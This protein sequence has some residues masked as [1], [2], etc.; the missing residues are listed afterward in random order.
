MMAGK[1]AWP[2]K[3]LDYCL[4]ALS[5]SLTVFLAVA[6]YGNKNAGDDQVV[7]QASTGSWVYPITAEET[8]TI[9]GPLGETVVEIHDKKA[10]IVSSPCQGQTCV[11]QGHIHAQGES[12]ICL[13]NQVGVFIEG[14]SD[15]NTVDDSAY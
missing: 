5:L 13:P 8:I 15:G 7:I 4:V 1:F 11:A 9:Q 12:V 2:M 3:P 10:R 14:K 6:V